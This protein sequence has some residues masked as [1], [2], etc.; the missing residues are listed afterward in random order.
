MTKVI[1]L[2]QEPKEEKKLKPIQFV[3]FLSSALNFQ[4][5]TGLPKNFDH[6]E[7]IRRNYNH[8]YDLMYVYNE[9]RNEGTLYLGHFNDGVVE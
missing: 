2:G 6:I 3:K 4:Y 7:L 8:E 1:I 9:D 5:S